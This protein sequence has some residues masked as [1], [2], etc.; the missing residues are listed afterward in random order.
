MDRDPQKDEHQDVK[1]PMWLSLVYPVIAVLGLLGAAVGGML[2]YLNPG[3]G[4]PEYRLFVMH[5][6]AFVLLFFF[7][8]LFVLVMAMIPV[9]A[10]IEE[11]KT[12]RASTKFL[13]RSSATAYMIM[14]GFCAFVIFEL[15]NVV[16]ERG[17]SQY[18]DSIK[19]EIS[20]ART[21]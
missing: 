8:L 15:I 12:K 3:D 16:A 11:S 21:N 6:S 20:M 10:G 14:A 7:L 18:I 5:V 19:A 2:H 9:V 1:K 13:I 17:I 4:S